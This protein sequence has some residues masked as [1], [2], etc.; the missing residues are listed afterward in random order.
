MYDFPGKEQELEGEQHEF[1]AAMI[2]P[3]EEL[4]PPAFVS[5]R[6]LQIN[7][8]FFINP[9]L[10]DMDFL[11]GYRYS[12]NGLLFACGAPH[13]RIRDAQLWSIQILIERGLKPAWIPLR[14]L[15]SVFFAFVRLPAI[16]EQEYPQLCHEFGQAFLQFMEWMQTKWEAD[17][18]DGREVEEE[19]WSDDS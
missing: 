1:T 13:M 17:I 19:D 15:E 5:T 12:N 11:Q 8:R 3:A 7:E 14:D 18:F 4:D 2:D 10:S 16:V 9:T 6:K